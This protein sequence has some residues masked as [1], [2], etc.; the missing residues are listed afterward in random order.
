M[1]SICVTLGARTPLPACLPVRSVFITTTGEAPGTNRLEVVGT[2]GKLVS[3]AGVLTFSQNSIASDAAIRG[4]GDLKTETYQ[5]R[6]GT[7]LDYRTVHD[8]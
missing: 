7:G 1:V 5:V 4:E 2:K 3:E 6:T 8:M